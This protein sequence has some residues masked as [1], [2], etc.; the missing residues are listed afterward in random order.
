MRDGLPE[1]TLLIRP[2]DSG[3]GFFWEGK[4][5]WDGRQVKRRL[6]LAFVA[7]RATPLHAEPGER[8]EAW[9]LRYVARRGKAPEGALTPTRAQHA[10]QRE[11]ATYAEAAARATREAVQ[12]VSGAAALVLF[13]ALA[14]DWLAERKRDVQDGALKSSTL[15]DYRSMLRRPDEALRP[16]GTARRD[17]LDG[18]RVAWLMREWEFEPVANI[19]AEAMETL[20]R[21]LGDAGLSLRTR[22]KYYVV[23]SL[24][25]SHGVRRKVID[26]NPLAELG[27]RRRRRV[28]KPP[29]AVYDLHVVESIAAKAGGDIGECIRLAALTGLRQGEL[30][31]LRWH[32]VLWSERALFVRERYLPGDE[33]DA[34][35]GVDLPKSNRGRTVPL[36]D[37]AAL[38]LERVSERDE[39]TNS[40]DLVFGQRDGDPRPRSGTPYR[41]THRDPSALRR[42]YA[43]ARDHVVSEAAD[44]GDSLSTLR[45]H[46]L[47]HTFGTQCAAAGVPLSTIQQWM[48]HASIQT[49]MVYVH[50]QPQHDDAARLTRAFKVGT[51]SEAERAAV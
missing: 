8:V 34:G 42:E 7:E 40:R 31:A 15:R 6:G 27:R 30:L 20:E 45:F 12:E 23:V 48:G 14:D 13:G 3:R 25:L 32:D 26:H 10:L 21:R 39:W 35:D 9:R 18:G 37:Q 51:V 50:W 4:W 49:T 24:I 29:I 17:D 5:R 19:T 11:I 1:G 36:S 28:P 2:A 41:W 16:R 44:A 22:R 43:K 33:V 38:V 46:D 47:R